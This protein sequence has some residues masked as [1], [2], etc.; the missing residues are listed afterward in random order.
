MR[1]MSWWIGMGVIAVGVLA[2]CGKS[3]TMEHEVEI[4]KAAEAMV[5]YCGARVPTTMPIEI[6]P[7]YVQV[8]MDVRMLGLSDQEVIAL[9]DVMCRALVGT[10]GDLGIDVKAERVWVDVGA[11]STGAGVSPTGEVLMHLY[12]ESIYNPYEDRVVW[13]EAKR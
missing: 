1:R 12:G 9:T 8:W 2:G 7:G 10:I 4:R 6:T 13:E 11:I 3:P 5:A